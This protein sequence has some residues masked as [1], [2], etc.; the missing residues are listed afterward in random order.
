MWVTRII[1]VRELNASSLFAQHL[2]DKIDIMIYL[3]YNILI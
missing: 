1:E 3:F 2:N